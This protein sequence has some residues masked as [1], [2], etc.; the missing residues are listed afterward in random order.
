MSLKVTRMV[1][2]GTYS[3]LLDSSDCN[4]KS[5]NLEYFTRGA[6]FVDDFG[7]SVGIPLMKPIF[8]ILYLGMNVSIPIFLSSLEAIRVLALI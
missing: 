8:S 2:L 5:M 6:R 3:T 4:V 7:T 1:S